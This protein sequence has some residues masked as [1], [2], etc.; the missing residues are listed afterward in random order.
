MQLFGPSFFRVQPP[1]KKHHERCK[2]VLFVRSRRNP[3]ASTGE[4]RRSVRLVA[5]GSVTVWQ[6]MIGQPRAICVKIVVAPLDRA[7]ETGKVSDVT[8]GRRFEPSNP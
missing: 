7:Q 2:A 6:T 5:C 8:I 4:D 3:I 1:K